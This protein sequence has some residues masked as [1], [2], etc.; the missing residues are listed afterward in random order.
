MNLI[1]NNINAIRFAIAGMGKMGGYHLN[2]LQ[3]L[4]AADYEEYYKGGICE[5]LGKISIS[6]I[7]DIALEKIPTNIS[8]RFGSVEE[9]LDKT[10]PHILIIATPTQTHKKIAIA[11]LERGIHTF[12]EKPIVTSLTEFEE[13]LLL[14]EKNKC[15]L[16]AGHVERYNPVSVKIV[17]LLKNIKPLA[18]SY[19]FV[20]TQK[21]D[22]RIADDIITDKIIHDLDLSLY[23]FGNIESIKVENYKLVDNKVYEACLSLQ[24]QNG[25]KGTIFVSWLRDSSVKERKVEI[26]Q[27]GH[28]WT[29]DLVRKQLWVDDMEIKCMVDGM[30]KPSNNQ[31]K[32]ELFDFVAFCIGSESLQNTAPLLSLKEIKHVIKWLETIIYE[33]NIGIKK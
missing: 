6:G 14:A 23:F 18:D 24:H 30:I 11:S 13:L 12:V 15:R 29:G 31:I 32:D 16:M 9:M 28:K 21:H 2:A 20:R 5:Q 4:M 22:S 26:L 8:R 7:C 27:G 19:S 25:I 10:K 1:P 33:V 17:S 3:Q